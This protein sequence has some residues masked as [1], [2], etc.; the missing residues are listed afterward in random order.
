MELEVYRNQLGWLTKCHIS[1]VNDYPKEYCPPII[2]P[3]PPGYH[4]NLEKG[5]QMA[6]KGIF[7]P[8]LMIILKVHPLYRALNRSRRR[9]TRPR[10]LLSEHYRQMDRLQ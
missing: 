7:S 2:L 1:A 4:T 5:A 3:I 6:A 9:M 8:T 10:V